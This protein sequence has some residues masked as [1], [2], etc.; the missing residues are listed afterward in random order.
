MVSC[1]RAW[2]HLMLSRCPYIGTEVMIYA[3]KQVPNE[4]RRALNLRLKKNR[5]PLNPD[6]QSQV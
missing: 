2:V 3:T 5:K 4:A 6:T 1:T